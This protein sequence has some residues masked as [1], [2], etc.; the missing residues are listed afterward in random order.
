MYANQITFRSS[1]ET[2]ERLGCE[3]CV[4]SSSL[5]LPS[6]GSALRRLPFCCCSPN[7][8]TESGNFGESQTF[9]Q[10]KNVVSPTNGKIGR[11]G[12]PPPWVTDQSVSRR[13]PNR[14]KLSGTAR[15][16]CPE[17]FGIIAIH[18]RLPANSGC[19]LLKMKSL[20]L[21]HSSSIISSVSSSS[22]PSP[23]KHQHQQE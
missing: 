9:T 11:V 21:T 2:S 22:P 14:H 23:A 15:R 8:A 17:G 3:C 1:I 20:N 4:C 16:P 13:D 12:S 6:L 5:L 18:L 19:Q 10:V 7:L